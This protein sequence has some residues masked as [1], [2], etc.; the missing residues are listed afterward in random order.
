MFFLVEL[1]ETKELLTKVDEIWR[2]LESALN[3]EVF[4][5]VVSVSVVA[6]FGSV[7]F[8]LSWRDLC[9]Y[10]VERC[11]RRSPG[12]GKVFLSIRLRSIGPG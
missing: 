12:S 9:R 10:W 6:F 3:A 5:G 4:C 1:P 8:C 11:S 2:G 7:W